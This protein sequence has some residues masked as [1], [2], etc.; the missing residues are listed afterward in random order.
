[1]LRDILEGRTDFLPMGMSITRERNSLFDFVFPLGYDVAALY[2]RKDKRHDAPQWLTY[3]DP[4]SALLW[5]VLA[6]SSLV[7]T[8]S[9]LAQYAV[10]RDPGTPIT[11]L[12]SVR[13]GLSVLWMTFA[14]YFGRRLNRFPKHVLIRWTLFTGLLIGNFVFISYRL[15]FMN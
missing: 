5:L 4:L 10:A 8:A 13:L 11:V 7:L 9:A 12:G 1:M 2:V 6:T 14:V 15:S 3:V